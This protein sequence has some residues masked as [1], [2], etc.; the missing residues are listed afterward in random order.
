MDNSCRYLGVFVFLYIVT[1]IYF[2]ITVSND[3]TIPSNKNIV[4][5]IQRDQQSSN[6]KLKGNMSLEQEKYENFKK[7]TL[8]SILKSGRT[9]QTDYVNHLLRNSGNFNAT[10]QDEAKSQHSKSTFSSFF[11]TH[12]ESTKAIRYD[13]NVDFKNEKINSRDNNYNVLKNASR[14][15]EKSLQT[16]VQP[17]QTKSACVFYFDRDSFLQAKEKL[18]EPQSFYLFYINV[19]G[20]PFTKFSNTERDDLLHWQYIVK[21]EKYIVQL[22][23]DF[24]LITFYLLLADKE[25]TVLSLTLLYNKSNCIENFDDAKQSIRILLWNELFENNTGFFLCNRNYK[26]EKGRF[27]MYA[28]TTIWIGFDLTCSEIIREIG[29]LE[30]PITKEDLPL[31][32]PIFCYLMSLQ[33]VWFLVLLDIED[34]HQENFKD[35]DIP[36]SNYQNQQSNV[37]D[38]ENENQHANSRAFSFFYIRHD[39]P[40]GLKRFFIKLLYYKSFANL[41]ADTQNKC[42]KCLCETA[43]STRLILFVWC[44][45]LVPVGL[46]RTIGRYCLGMHIYNDYLNVVLPSEPLFYI[47]NMY[48][49]SLSSGIVLMFDIVYAIVCPLLLLWLVKVPYK[50]Y[51]FH[52]PY[53]CHAEENINKKMN[54]KRNLRDRFIFPCSLICNIICLKHCTKSRYCLWNCCFPVYLIMCLFPFVPFFCA[55]YKSYLCSKR[56]RSIKCY[57]CFCIR[58]I[59]K[60]ICMCFVFLIS[61]FICFRSV[62]SHF[63]FLF[64]SFTYIFFVAL[65]IRVDIMQFTLVLGS[66]I[67]YISNY[68]CEIINMNEE[69]LEHIFDLKR[70]KKEEKQSSDATNPKEASPKQSSK[71]FFAKITTPFSSKNKDNQKIESQNKGNKVHSDECASS[72]SFSTNIVNS[73]SI[74]T[75][76]IEFINE[77][78]F[79]AVYEQLLFV[80]KWLYFLCVKSIVVIVYFVIIVNSFLFDR[81]SMN[82]PHFRDIF[83]IIL[84]IIGPYAISFLL[85]GNKHNFL[86]TENKSE[87]R[88]AYIFYLSN[89][90]NQKTKKESESR[91]TESLRNKRK[92]ITDHK[93]FSCSIAMTTFSPNNDRTRLLDEENE[94]GYGTMELKC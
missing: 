17:N 63:T 83:S 87:I 32:Y 29:I 26:E 78:E 52:E 1:L 21:G 85:K 14:R 94:M 45:I 36:E 77:E 74:E 53:I 61:Y 39:R 60:Y 75:K 64:R 27:W 19:E 54:S 67:V 62:I 84:V 18:S 89:L 28:I 22:P 46:Y 50:A 25:E 9:M 48:I 24:D 57:F 33:F 68:I 71:G 20:N 31:I 23:V 58:S 6:P 8:L 34:I 15:G 35:Q 82:A 91:R 3:T 47:I 40:Y 56:C 90:G 80:N 65:P 42:C 93:S 86:N 10:V 13:H 81:K 44:T 38:K 5:I 7:S 41:S 55:G 70:E 16:F 11:L 2:Y 79:D 59:M 12:T 49:V 73:T 30:Y 66:I 92:S 4:Q 37:T 51:M 76:Q 69:I 43:P 72:T 88:T